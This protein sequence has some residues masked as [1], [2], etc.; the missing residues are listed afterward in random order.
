LNRAPTTWAFLGLNVGRYGH[1][2]CRRTSCPQ[3]TINNSIIPTKTEI[4][5]LG[6]HL[7]QKLTWKT[8][9]RMKRQ[10]VRLKAR[11]MNWLIGNRSQLSLENKVLLYKAIL[12]PIWTYGI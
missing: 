10:Q 7:D 4:K 11:Q 3:V 8:H 5:Y 9:I 1:C 12:M 6:L 2:Q